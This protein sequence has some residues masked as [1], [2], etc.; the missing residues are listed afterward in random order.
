MKKITLLFLVWI[1]TFGQT[2]AQG[3]KTDSK[4]PYALAKRYFVKNN[5]PDKDFHMLKISSEEKFNDIFGIAPLSGKDGEPTKIDFSKSFVIA[6]ID[7]TSN[8]TENIAV[9][10]L[11]KTKDNL[12][13]T[14]NIK[15]RS[16]ASSAYFRF[17]E[18]LIVDKKHEAK[19]SLAEEN[20]E[21]ILGGD[22]D[23]NGCKPST[24]Y[25]WSI[26]EN[27]CIAPYETKYILEGNSINEFKNAALLFSKDGSKAEII[28]SKYGKNIILDKKAKVWTNGNLTITT[29][30]KDNFV[31]TQGKK[32]I[33][34]G[35]LRK[36]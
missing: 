10:S 26:L 2:N 30:K 8:L 33:A 6:L 20:S 27:S 34:K 36:F 23:E 31:L 9:K 35:K 18:L 15:N 17:C 5:Y 21:P 32:S 14:Y 1:A 29:S 11:T 28:G 7:K 3:L 13:L 19:V 4:V 16:Q 24:G 12:Q 25:C 22:T